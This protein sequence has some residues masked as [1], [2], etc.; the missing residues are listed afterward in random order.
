MRL[1]SKVH[2]LAPT[3]QGKIELSFVPVKS[4]PLVN[5]I[6]VEEESP[7]PEQ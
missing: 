5:A 1:W 3:A 4:F 7:G 6:E 2:N